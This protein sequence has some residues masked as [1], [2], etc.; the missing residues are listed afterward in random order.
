M[1]VLHCKLTTPATSNNFRSSLSVAGTSL[2][3]S[4]PFSC[5]SLDSDSKRLVSIQTTIET[6]HPGPGDEVPQQG[7]TDPGHRAD[8]LALHRNA[9]P[10]RF[11]QAACWSCRMPHDFLPFRPDKKLAG[12]VTGWDAG[13][14]AQSGFPQPGRVQPQDAV[15]SP[16]FWQP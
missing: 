10:R 15:R 11:F 12:S 7:K 14:R 3:P 1:K 9:S 6:S 2:S 16:A 13:S 4:L 5:Y 8:R